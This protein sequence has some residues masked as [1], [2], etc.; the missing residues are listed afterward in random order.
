MKSNFKILVVF[1]IVFS[2]YFSLNTRVFSQTADDLY[3]LG[4]AENITVAGDNLEGGMI[5]T[6]VD[7]QYA[8][9]TEEFDPYTFGVIS[10]TPAVE[11]I[12]E[13][14]ERETVP[15]VTKG[16]TPVKVT[17]Q[18]GAISIGDRITTSTNPGVAMLANKSGLTLGVSQEDFNPENPE[19]IGEI[20]VTLDIKFTLSRSLTEKQQVNNKLLDVVNLSTIAALE[21]PQEVLKYVL[22]AF[23]L[24]GSVAFSFLVFG[25]SAQNSILALGRNPLASKAISLGMVLNI[26]MSLFIIISG[27]LTSWFVINL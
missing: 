13:D 6:Y 25:R 27:I 9:A 8:L 26:A 4:I 10:N 19:E 11:F 23:I 20:I 16:S 22:A 7:G 12:Y 14:I 1:A 5:V 24:V 17:A 2:L 18:N 3:S 15:V 21:E